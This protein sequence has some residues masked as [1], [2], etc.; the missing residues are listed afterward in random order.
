MVRFTEEWINTVFPMSLKAKF[1]IWASVLYLIVALMGVQLLSIHYW[2]F[3]AAEGGVIIS[4]FL[5]LW[6]YRSFLQPISDISDGVKML[7]E[8]DFNS[9]LLPVGQPEI[10]NLTTVYNRMVEALRQERLRQQ[11]THFFL[12]RLIDASPLGILILDFDEKISEANPAALNTM[13]L[14]LEKAIGTNIS[15]LP[16]IWAKALSG[17]DGTERKTV[18]M[19]SGRTYRVERATFVDRGFNRPFILLE[20]QTDEVMALERQA[21]EKVIRMMSHEVNN[22]VGAINSMLVSLLSFASSLAESDR[23]DYT[24]AL[25]VSIARNQSLSS[26]MSNFA[27][28]VKLPSPH[29]TRVDI[30]QVINSVLRLLAPKFREKHITLDASFCNPALYV[31][32]DQTQIEQVLVNVL[33]NAIEAISGEGIIEVVTQNNPPTLLIRNNGETIAPESQKRLFTPFFST[34]RNGQGV[35]LM[36][37][38][39]VLVNHAFAFNLETLPD[40]FTEFRVTFENKS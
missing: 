21:Y 28:V 4:F 13:E 40:G 20:E 15:A 27:S 9:R 32:A 33:K 23:G 14:T 36:L 37:V 26:F 25:E 16:S 7:E 19:N 6:F 18:R 10:D 24:S 39:E 35:G 11:E 2:Y 8:Q 30:H 34:R 3:F 17:I 12:R 38:R 1:W 5:L 29:H 22:S 31:M